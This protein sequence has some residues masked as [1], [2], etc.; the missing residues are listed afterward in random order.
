MILF[1]FALLFL[2]LLFNND[3]KIPVPTKDVHG[4]LVSTIKMAEE[5]VEIRMTIAGTRTRYAQ[6]SLLSAI[7][8]TVDKDCS[9]PEPFRI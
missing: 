4:S 2:Q 9:R 7:A 5:V 6:I 3:G 8:T 1:F